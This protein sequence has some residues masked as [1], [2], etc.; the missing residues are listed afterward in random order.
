MKKI[1][2]SIFILLSFLGFSQ[3]RP[4]SQYGLKAGISNSKTAI[5]DNRTNI[6]TRFRNDMNFGLFYRYNHS[7]FSV[8]PEVYFQVKGG[9]FKS[10]ST[11]FPETGN[12]IL[13]NNYQYLDAAVLVGYEFAKNVH[14]VVGP[15][16]G[17]ALN[18][19]AKRGP[20]A[21]SD[22]SIATGVRIDMLDIAHLASLNIRYVHGFTNTTNK[23][24]TLADK[25]VIPL[26]FRNR[27][28][29]VSASFTISDF[30][31]AKKMRQ[32]KQK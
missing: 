30:L 17:R 20:Y 8:Q 10:T 11:N 14:F 7:K 21:E 5:I 12:T 3:I 29:Q 1:L 25:S 26:D 23:T 18:A 16:Y 9:S 15:E 2:T 4:T 13:R 6:L 24:Y 19:G 22:F 31:K 32:K 27:T 28:L